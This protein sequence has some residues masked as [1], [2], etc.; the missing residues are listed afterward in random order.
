M[1]GEGVKSIFLICRVT[2][3][4]EALTDCDQVSVLFSVKSFMSDWHSHYF[5]V[6]STSTWD[7]INRV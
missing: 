6:V 2:L 1:W 4:L 5:L 3:L 7:L